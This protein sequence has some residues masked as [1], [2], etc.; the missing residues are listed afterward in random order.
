MY[1]I[2]YI[3]KASARIDKIN[4]YSDLSSFPKKSWKF[5]K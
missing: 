5:D 2:Y 3:F 4:M 1:F